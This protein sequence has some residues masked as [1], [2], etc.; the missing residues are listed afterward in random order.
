MQVCIHCVGVESPAFFLPVAPPTLCRPYQYA[1]VAFAVVG[2]PLAVTKAVALQHSSWPRRDWPPFLALYLLS[3]GLSIAHLLAA[4][5]VVVWAQKRWE[6]GLGS[7]GFP[8]AE[9]ED[10]WLLAGHLESQLREEQHY[11]RH[12][13]GGA[14]GSGG[15][16]S[17]SV[18]DGLG[19]DMGDDLPPE[20]LA[21]PDSRFME[22]QGLRIHYKAALPQ[23][24]TPPGC[25]EA[26]APAAAAAA[27][28]A[29]RAEPGTPAADMGLLLIHSFGGGAFSWRHLLQPLADACG[30]PVVAFDRPG[31]GAPPPL[32]LCCCLLR[33]WPWCCV[34][35]LTVG[36][37]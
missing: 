33:R 11:K 13:R 35:L 15:A 2:L 32:L 3:A 21:D 14:A 27:A 22:C 12:R 8:W 31:F 23:G 24:S 10:T 6:A 20:A 34:L 5:R 1:A 17:A 18:G 30:V 29:T 7:F 4:Q 26:W 16:G 37:P 19:L 36:A 25:P 28:G 9:G